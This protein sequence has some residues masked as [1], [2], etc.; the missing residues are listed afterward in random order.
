MSGLAEHLGT[1]FP[2]ALTRPSVLAWLF[3]VSLVLF[4]G[5]LA[6]IPI[7]IARMRADYFVGSGAPDETWIGWHPLARV[8]MR[9][10]KNLLGVVLLF[11]GIAMMVLPGQGIIT[12]LVAL[13]LLDFPG[14]RRLEIRIIRQPHVR[15][16]VNWVR[17]RARRPPLTIPETSRR[18]T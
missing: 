14:K 1:L 9:V 10:V 13:T 5:S 8:S 6:V 4:V 7:L 3:G 15:R 12:V 16:A 11:A 17:T 18:S 2:D